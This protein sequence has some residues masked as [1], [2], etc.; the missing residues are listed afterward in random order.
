MGEPESDSNSEEHLEVIFCVKK[1]KLQH[2]ICRGIY[3]TTKHM[4]KLIVVRHAKSSWADLGQKDFDR[5]LN[6]RGNNDAPRMAQKLIAEGVK[7]DAFV[8]SSA[9]RARQTCEAFAKE[10]GRDKDEIIYFDRLYHAP[11][12]VYHDVVSEMNNN[13]ETIAI[14]GH[15]TG[16]SDFVNTLHKNDLGFELPTCAIFAVKA[17]IGKWEDFKKADKKLLFFKYPKQG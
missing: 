6:D 12:Q 2:N 9:K 13:R 7:I 17:D 8:S 5:P 10:Y 16:I 15:N 4:K 11:S 14:F 3:R 1:N